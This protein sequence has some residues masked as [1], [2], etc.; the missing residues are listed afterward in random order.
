MVLVRT[1]LQ[2]VQSAK[3]NPELYFPSFSSPGF[4]PLLDF[5]LCV[6]PSHPKTTQKN[7]QLLGVPTGEGMILN[8]QFPSYCWA[9]GILL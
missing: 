5:C 2:L 3:T 1:E 7:S 8:F 9:Q 4:P 6:F